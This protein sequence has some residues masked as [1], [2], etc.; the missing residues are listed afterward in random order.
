MMGT[1]YFSNAAES[2][3]D[4]DDDEHDSETVG[5]KGAAAAAKLVGAEDWQT[6]SSP[7]ARAQSTYAA[8]SSLQSNQAALSKHRLRSQSTDFRTDDRASGDQPG[9]FVDP[10]ILR[11]QT[12]TKDNKPLVGPGK[13][14]PVGQLVAFFDSERS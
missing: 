8:S 1:A 4:D 11:R 7:R 14:V 12:R 3:D 2:S 6:T 5:K 13:K 9:R 10:L